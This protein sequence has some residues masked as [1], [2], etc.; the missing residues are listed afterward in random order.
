VPHLEKVIEVCNVT[1]LK[2]DSLRE[3]LK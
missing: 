3:D 2:L 1:I